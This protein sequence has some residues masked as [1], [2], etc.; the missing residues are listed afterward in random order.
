[1]YKYRIKEYL[2]ELNIKEYHF[3]MKTIPDIIGVGSTTF[4]T[5]IDL[6]SDCKFDISHQKVVLL[7]KLFGV[8]PG[9]LLSV[10]VDS[11][12]IQQLYKKSKKG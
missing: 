6:P 8:H 4:R 11:E 2:E 12:T 3:A 7:E 5:Y 10:P 9:Q 1:M